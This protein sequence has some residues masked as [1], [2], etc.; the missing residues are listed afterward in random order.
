[1]RWFPGTRILSDVLVF[2]VAKAL[3]G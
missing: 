3:S 1:M 2:D